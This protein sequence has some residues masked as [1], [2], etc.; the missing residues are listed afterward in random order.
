MHDNCIYCHI[1]HSMF[2]I[3]IIPAGDSFYSIS[4]AALSPPLDISGKGGPAPFDVT[5][6]TFYYIA[7]AYA[8]VLQINIDDLYLFLLRI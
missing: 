2:L 8:N 4:G 3:R 1:V 6:F 5:I 7:D